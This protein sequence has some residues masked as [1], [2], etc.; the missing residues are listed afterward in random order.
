L[1]TTP[2]N[3][4]DPFLSHKTSHRAAYARADSEAGEHCAPLLFN[5]QGNVTESS[6][7]NIVY[8]YD[9]KLYTPP[10]QDGLLPGVLR[11]CLLR[12]GQVEVRSLALEETAQVEAWWVVNA[13]RGWRDCQLVTAE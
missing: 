5:E 12:E 4:A 11:E 6:I 7:A 13:L 2:V 3:S 9:G 1:V 8:Q 10:V